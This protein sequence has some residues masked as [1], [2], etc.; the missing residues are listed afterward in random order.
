[1]CAASRSRYHLQFA[2]LQCDL[3]ASASPYAATQNVLVKNEI[4]ISGDL[5]SIKNLVRG[6]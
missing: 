2:E 6:L 1:M 3:Q 4:W 5:S